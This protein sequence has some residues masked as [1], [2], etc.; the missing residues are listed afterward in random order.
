VE[1][2]SAGY[3]QQ[4][5]DDFLLHWGLLA[6]GVELTVRRT[7]G[8]DVGRLEPWTR[9]LAAQARRAWW[10]LPA[11]LLRLRRFPQRY[12][13]V[14]A[15]CDV[16]LSPAT[17]APAPKLGHLGG[18]LSY[19]EH[20]ARLLD[21]VPFT[22]IQNASGTPAIS[23]PVGTTAAGLPIGAQLAAPWGHERRLLELAFALEA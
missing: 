9:A 4:L 18:Q 13:Q 11:A 14:F 5:V 21:L 6:A 16:V 23:V 19:D 15:A 12:A 3:D 20:L 8:A 2:I 10:R 17:A 7:P 22:P 1:P